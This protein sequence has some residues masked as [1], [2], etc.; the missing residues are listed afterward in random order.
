MAISEP[1][2]LERVKARARNFDLATYRKEVQTHFWHEVRFESLPQALSDREFWVDPSF[3]V[4]RD[5][6]DRKGHLIAIKGQRVNPLKTLPFHQKLIV[7]NGT[8]PAEVDR[9]IQEIRNASTPQVTLMATEI[10]RISGWD[11]LKNLEMKVGIRVF[12]LTP[13]LR[14]RFKLAATPSLIEAVDHQFRIREIGMRK[15]G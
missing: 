13:D 7:F 4:P 10:K 12:L 14:K 2:L 8:R 11:G 1:D 9:V 15:G 3:T 5:L 6:R